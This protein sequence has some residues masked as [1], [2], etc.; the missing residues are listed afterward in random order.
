MNANA[1]GTALISSL[2]PSHFGQSVTFTATVTGAS[3][4]GTVN[5]SGTGITGCGAQALNGSGVATCTTTTIPVGS[6]TVTAGYSGDANNAVSSKTVT[7]TVNAAT[8]GTVIVS[9][10][11]PSSFGESVTFT[12]TVTGSSPTGTVAFTGGGI[13]SCAAQPLSGRVV[14]TCTTAGLAVGADSPSP[15]PI[16]GTATT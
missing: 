6:E 2:N 5:F 1:S 8:S 4:T 15:P 16:A 7:Q 9:S 13:T 12:A 3:P 10:Q 14:A 11:N